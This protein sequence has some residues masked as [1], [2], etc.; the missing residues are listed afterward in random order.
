ME[1]KIDVR[2]D[3]ELARSEGNSPAEMIRMAVAG[4]ADL[5]KL[6]K[7]LGLQERWEA[8]EARKA[9]HQ[10]MADFKANSPRI[11]RDKKN[12]QYD[13]MYTT[14][15]NLV[16]TVNPELSKNGLSASWDIKQNGIIS[17]TCKIT[18]KL[19]HSECSSA[20]APSDASGSKN[21][22]QQIKSTVTYLKAVT[23]EAI[24]GLASSEANLDDD[25]LAAATEFIKDQEI[26][27]LKDYI[28][29]LGA[30]EEKF[31]KYL[32]VESL[33]KIPM[34]DYQKALTALKAKEKK[35]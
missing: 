26:I 23:F 28:T 17:V 13:S 32:G 5:E 15:G 20:S 9:F 2:K 14:L 12:K 33:D 16:N 21:A 1:T 22:I 24:T 34:G 31:L 29:S 19:G 25:G 18:H 8:N 11:T 35:K 30:N 4:G 27:I 10:A 7:L 3:K 6:E